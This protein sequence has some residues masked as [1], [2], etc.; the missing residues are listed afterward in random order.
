M[1]AG[2]ADEASFEEDRVVWH[3]LCALQT[4]SSWARLAGIRT[5]TRQ[6]RPFADLLQDPLIYIL[7]MLASMICGAPRYIAI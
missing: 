1:T 4:P 3:H 5:C 2:P 7:A 6:Q